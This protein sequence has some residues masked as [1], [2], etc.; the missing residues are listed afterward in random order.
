VRQRRETN[1]VLIALAA[2][3]AI[4]SMIFVVGFAG[5]NAHTPIPTPPPTTPGSTTRPHTTASTGTNASGKHHAKHSAAHATYRIEITAANGDSYVMAHLHSASGPDA[6]TIRHTD[7]GNYLLH[8]G[9][10]AVVQAN[11]PVHLTLGAPGNVTIRVAGHDRTLP[12][13][14]TFTI[15][16]SGISRAA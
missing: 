5:S 8:Q 12:P 4:A 14:Q 7:L 16:R 2:I 3:V 10:V 15:T 6:V 9:E 1:I 13:G 11:G